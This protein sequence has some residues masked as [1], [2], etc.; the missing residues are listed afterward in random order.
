[1]TVSG[2]VGLLIILAVGWALGRFF[3]RPRRSRELAYGLIQ[4]VLLDRKDAQI[5][6]LADQL[7]ALAVR[8]A[9]LE[10]ELTEARRSA[11]L[12]ERAPIK[13]VSARLGARRNHG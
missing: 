1:M 5:G 9:Q 6:E 7:G 2:F 3:D 13:V 11:A 12:N 8:N 4:A 10:T